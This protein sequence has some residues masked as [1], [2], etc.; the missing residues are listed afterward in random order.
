M[1]S[2]STPELPAERCGTCF[3]ARP[4]DDA[5]GVLHDAGWLHCDLMRAWEYVA[6]GRACHFDPGKWTAKP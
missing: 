6:P 5:S 3:N 2:P 1:M 4:A